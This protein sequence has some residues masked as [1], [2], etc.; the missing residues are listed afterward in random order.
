[1]NRLFYD[2]ENF[3]QDISKWDVSN[4]TDMSGMFYDASLFN[5]DISVWDLSKVTTT[6]RM[7]YGT[8]FNQDISTGM[9]V[10]L[11]T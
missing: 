3:D 11:Q 6:S 5:H 9:L 4:T 1:M 2:D 7:F 8:S 10:I